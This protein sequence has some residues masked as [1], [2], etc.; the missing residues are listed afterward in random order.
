MDV[1]TLRNHIKSVFSSFFFYYD[2]IIIVARFAT[3]CVG[4]KSIYCIISLNAVSSS[5]VFN[6]FDYV[7]L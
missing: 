4:F 5:V 2:F 6:E 3:K 1:S 7:F